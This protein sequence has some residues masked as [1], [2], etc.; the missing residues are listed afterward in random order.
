MINSGLAMRN[1]VIRHCIKFGTLNFTQN[2][3]KLLLI[4]LRMVHHRL[5][6]REL[7]FNLQLPLPRESHQVITTVESINSIFYNSVNFS[8]SIANVLSKWIGSLLSHSWFY[9]WCEISTGR[10]FTCSNC[11]FR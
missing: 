7:S 1:T 3:Y 8:C 9:L 10:Q 4:I 6:R 2:I 11:R 5:D